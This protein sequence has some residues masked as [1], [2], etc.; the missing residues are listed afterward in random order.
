MRQPVGVVD[1][2]TKV[3]LGWSF[4][5]GV[6]ALRLR[7]QSMGG[8]VLFGYGWISYLPPHLPRILLELWNRCLWGTSLA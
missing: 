7:D 1:L 5:P 6:G 4:D 8:E 3:V 2:E